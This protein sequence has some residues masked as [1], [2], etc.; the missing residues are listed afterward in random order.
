MDHN[1]YMPLTGNSFIAS[2]NYTTNGTTSNMT[3]AQWQALG[4]DTHSVVTDSPNL[5]T[6]NYVPASS[7]PCLAFG[8]D[9]GPLD[10]YSGTVYP[11][12]ETVGAYEIPHLNELN[13]DIDSNVA[14]G[15]TAD[16]Y[17]AAGQILNVNLTFSPSI[18]AVLTVINNSSNNPINGTFS[19]LPDQGVI[20][21]TLDGITYVCTANYKG[22]TGNDLTLTV[23]SA[24][25]LFSEWQTLKFGANAT[26][27]LIA[28]ASAIPQ[29][30]GIP[31]LLKYLYN[32]DPTKPMTAADLAAL[33]TAGTNTS[34]NPGTQYL[35]LTY[36][37]NRF[38]TGTTINVQTSSDLQTWTTLKPTDVP[39]DF[40]SQQIGAD[41]T[42]GDPI[43]EVGVKF[44][45]AARQ[46]IR[47]NVTQP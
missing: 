3:F 18:G 42:T 24:F 32:I 36:R 6:G 10:D 2:Q 33:P 19:N 16:G 35:T 44:T 4:F 22:G 39:P 38:L 17:T 37:Q 28:G 1:V 29:N 5:K 11:D 13:V 46:F 43:M 20:N 25:M 34:T 15:V 31:N 40:L 27:P 8:V 23:N 21:L 7:N 9:I 14:V 30:D 26:N 41:L 45:G 47:L 12:R